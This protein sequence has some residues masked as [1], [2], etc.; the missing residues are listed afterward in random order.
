[1]AGC[2]RRVAAQVLDKEFVDRSGSRFAPEIVPSE[3][4]LDW[5]AHGSSLV[6]VGDGDALVRTFIER[7]DSEC[8][9]QLRIASLDG[10]AKALF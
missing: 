7:V 1:M 9:S 3:I 5:G 4:A 10:L 2:L 8:R 6:N